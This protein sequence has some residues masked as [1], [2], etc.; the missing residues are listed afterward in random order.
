MERLDN[1]V[2]PRVV[3]RLKDAEELVKTQ[4]QG[5]EEDHIV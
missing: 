4:S 3:E 5:K 2:M 1:G